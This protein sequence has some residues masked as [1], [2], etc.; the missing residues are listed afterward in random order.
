MNT[1]RA[2]EIASSPDLA[3]VTYNGVQ[4]YIQN[5]DD[6]NETARIFPLDNPQQEQDVPLSSL[7][8]N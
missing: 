8:E 3:N 7:E 1:Q 5:V 4:V 2:Q 6:K